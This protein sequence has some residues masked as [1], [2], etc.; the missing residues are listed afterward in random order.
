[1]RVLVPAVR[2]CSFIFGRPPVFDHLSSSTCPSHLSATSPHLP[3][4]DKPLP[5]ISVCPS[6]GLSPSWPL[7]LSPGLSPSLIAID[8]QSLIFDLCLWASSI[9]S[10][11]A[12]SLFI[13]LPTIV[14]LS[15]RLS[16][17][18]SISVSPFSGFLSL[19]PLSVPASLS[20]P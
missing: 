3:V 11:V 14:S 19:R 5:S 17:S 18:R 7:S 9:L 8:L 12:P 2:C 13:S 20:P 10:D 6:P 1:M 15:V 4:R 16:V